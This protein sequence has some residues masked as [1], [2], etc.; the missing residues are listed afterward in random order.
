MCNKKNGTIRWQSGH[1]A[2]RTNISSFHPG[3]EG[4]LLGARST[5]RKMALSNSGQLFCEL[6]W[7]RPLC[8][9][10]QPQAPQTF[11]EH[12]F[13]TPKVTG[14]TSL[15]PSCQSFP[16]KGSKKKKLPTNL[17]LLFPLWDSIET[18]QYYKMLVTLQAELNSLVPT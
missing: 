6:H 17:A 7:L 2:C 9:W 16:N 15:M 8:D 10:L 18:P 12:Y 3:W 13:K 11:K 4:T 5:F 1:M 14:L